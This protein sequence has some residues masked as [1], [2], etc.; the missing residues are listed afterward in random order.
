MNNVVALIGD[1]TW[2][3]RELLRMVRPNFVAYHIR[4]FNLAVKEILHKKKELI[5]KFKQ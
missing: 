5:E 3:N 1:K 2:T 4:H